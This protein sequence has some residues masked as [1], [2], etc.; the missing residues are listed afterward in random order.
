MG[1]KLTVLAAVQLSLLG[2]AAAQP[3]SDL[4]K[5]GI[6]A[7]KAGDYAKAAALLERAYKADPKPETLFALAQAERLGGKCDK[8][9]PHYNKLLEKTTELNQAKLIQNNV[10]LCEAS[11]DK[12]PDEPAKPVTRTV[13]REVRKSDRV[14]TAML[15]GGMLAIGSSVG[16]FL[17]ASGAASDASAAR[18]L[19]D[20]DRFLD[21]ATRDR[22]LAFVAGG[23]GAGLVVGAIVKW[24]LDGTKPTEVAVVP[25][26]SGA[27]FAVSGR[28]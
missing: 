7:Y 6:D 23:V 9:I 13:V 1:S 16:L 24:Q 21:R 3:A 22:V 27:T 19:D 20:H 4:Q 25:S 2:I 10:G 5:Q 12:K 18:T 17:A 26:A 28:W 8:A 11:L 15:G 14:A